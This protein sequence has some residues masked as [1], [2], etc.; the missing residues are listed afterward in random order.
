M[1]DTTSHPDQPSAPV[2]YSARRAGPSSVR[3][4]GPPGHHP[5]RGHDALEQERGEPGQRIADVA[6]GGQRTSPTAMRSPPTKRWECTQKPP[7]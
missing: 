7:R 1:H 3:I 5:G 2:G 4:A 6:A